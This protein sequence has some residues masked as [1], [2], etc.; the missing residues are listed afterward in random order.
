MRRLRSVGVARAALAPAAALLLGCS[1]TGPPRPAEDPPPNIRATRID[2]IDADGFDALLE[3]ALVN[4]EPVI[5]IY[6]ARE[7]PDWE[8]RLNAWIAAWSRGG[9]AGRTVRMQAPLP[10]VGV[11]ADSIREFRLLID[12]LMGRAEESAKAGAAWWAEERTRNR[13]VALLRPYSLRFHAADDGTIHLI[14]FNGRYAV[15]HSEFVRTLAGDDAEGAGEWVRGYF[16]S[17]CKPLRQ[18]GGIS[19]SE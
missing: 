6:T 12:D 13:R 19:P 5:E 4:Q 17:R 11:D 16:C 1:L 8:G 9:S 15:Y 3:S 14:F 7:K 2:Y 10:K 18:A